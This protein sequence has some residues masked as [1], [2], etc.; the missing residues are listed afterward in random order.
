[1]R[2]PEILPHTLSYD[3]NEADAYLACR[4]SATFAATITVLSELKRRLDN[5]NPQSIIDFGC[6]P[7]TSLWL[8]FLI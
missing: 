5:F 6:G 8:F 3:K 1:M 2:I 4:L 7:G